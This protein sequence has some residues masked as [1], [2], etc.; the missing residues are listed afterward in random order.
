LDSKPALTGIR[1]TFP[2][3]RII[4]DFNIM[5]LKRPILLA[6]FSAG[7]IVAASQGFSESIPAASKGQTVYVPVY[8]H[9]Y[10]GDREQKVLLTATLSIRNTDPVH[11]I[12][13]TSVDYYDSS[14]KLIRRYLQQPT[15]IMAMAAVRYVVAESDKSGGSGA[16]FVVKWNA[17]GYVRPPLIESVMIGTKMQQGISFTSRGQVIA[18]R[19]D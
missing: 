9:V 17:V 5:H 1:H 18:E 10:G 19:T 12:T 7:V 11:A 6:L 16:S 2:D 13:V 14:G 4:K 15:P 8:S 3:N